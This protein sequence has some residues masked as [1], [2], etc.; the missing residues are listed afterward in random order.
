[1]EAT[2]GS[3]GDRQ[4]QTREERIGSH[5]RGGAQHGSRHIAVGIIKTCPQLRQIGHRHIEIDQQRESH[6]EQGKGKDGIEPANDL[7]NGQHRGQNVIDQDHNHP[8]HRRPTE[9]FQQKGRTVDKHNTH[10][11]QEEDRKDEHHTSGRRAKIVADKLG[12]VSSSM[13][14]REHATQIIVH[15]T[16]KDTPEDDPQ[17]SHRS[18]PRTHDGTKDRACSSNIEKLD[19]EH[20]PAR[21]LDII[22]TI[23]HG[24]SRCGT[25]VGTEHALDNLAIEQVTDYQSQ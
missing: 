2:D 19:H 22:Y 3:A 17:V 11:Q 10:H 12:H 7:V 6:E 23:G 18:I 8:A 13:T 25:V 16:G 21:K 24:Y 20:F 9:I 4:E 5:I 15:G 14:H 1:M